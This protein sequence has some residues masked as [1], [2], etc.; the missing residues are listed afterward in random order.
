MSGLPTVPV[1]GPLIVTARV[2][3]E[4]VIEAVALAVAALASVTV[5]EIV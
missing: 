1:E 4:M 3:G 5:R 2:T